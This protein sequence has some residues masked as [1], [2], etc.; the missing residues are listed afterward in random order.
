MWSGLYSSRFRFCSIDDT[1]FFEDRYY[2][3]EISI[4]G[5]EIG[6]SPAASDLARKGKDDRPLAVY[7]TFPF[8]YQNASMG[9]RALRPLLE[10]RYGSEVPGRVLSYVWA[11][12][13]QRESN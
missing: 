3:E 1:T 11:S 8:D 12:S 6:C 10:F 2:K 5:M 13:N 7:I 9:E 4:L